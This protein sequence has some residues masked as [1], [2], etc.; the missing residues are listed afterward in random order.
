M[1]IF[2]IFVT[3]NN[4]HDHMKEKFYSISIEREVTPTASIV[5]GLGTQC[6]CCF[7]Y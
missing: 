1:N 6:F 2:T 7:Y 5:G 3:P 4:N